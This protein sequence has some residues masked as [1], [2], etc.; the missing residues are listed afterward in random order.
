MPGRLRVTQTRSTISHI[1]RNR[2]TIRALGLH[3]I[4]SSSILPDNPA[5]RGHGPPGPLPRRPSRSSPRARTRRPRRSTDEDPRPAPRR[6]VGH[7]ADPGRPRHRRR[8]G[9]DRRPRHEGPALARRR[10][11]PGLVRGRPDAPPHPDPEA[12]RLPQHQRHRVRGR[13]R[14]RDQR[15][16]RGRQAARSRRARRSRSTPT[17]SR[18]PAWSVATGCRS[19]SSATARS[20]AKLFVLADAFTQSAREKIEAAGG[21]AQ[22]IEIPTSPLA[23]LG[24]RVRPTSRRPPPSRAAPPRPGAKPPPRRPRPTSRRRGRGRRGGR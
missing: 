10:L 9:Q 8:Q 4:G 14:R 3:G 5:V 6:G 24:R 19:R 15:G 20:S 1:A 17:P 18:R 11:D 21:T 22:V 7:Q 12:P 23:A 16:D 13:Q 2:A